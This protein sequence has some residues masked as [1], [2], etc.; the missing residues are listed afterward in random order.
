MSLT[1]IDFD[2]DIL[3][4][5]PSYRLFK[6]IEHRM[7]LHGKIIRAI[8]EELILNKIEVATTCNIACVQADNTHAVG[9][10]EMKWL[11]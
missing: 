11:L 6:C 9:K 1:I 8:F 5:Y 3:F 7:S 10:E 2:Y 4:C